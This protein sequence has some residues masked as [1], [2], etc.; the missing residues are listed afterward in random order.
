M[1]MEYEPR[2]FVAHCFILRIL[3]N[4]WHRE[5]NGHLGIGR[6]VEWQGVCGQIGLKRRAGDRSGRS[7]W[8]TKGLDRKIMEM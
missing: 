6:W 3:Y 8:P 5:I 1:N 7:L 2:L 4:P